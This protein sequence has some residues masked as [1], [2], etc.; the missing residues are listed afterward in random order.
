MPTPDTVQLIALI[1]QGGAVVVLFL[2]NRDL[3]EQR[4]QERVERL[5]NAEVMRTI[6]A[7]LGDLTEAIEALIDGRSVRSPRARR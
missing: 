3:Q 7:S 6:G 5:A 1:I 4:K 2:W